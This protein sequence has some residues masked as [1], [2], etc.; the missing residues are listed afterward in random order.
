MPGALPGA[1][2]V[3]VAL[4]T[5][6]LA[7]GAF[8]YTAFVMPGDEFGLPDVPTS[9]PPETE[10]SGDDGVPTAEVETVE[11]EAI[12]VETIEVETAEEFKIS[13][14]LPAEETIEAVIQPADSEIAVDEQTSALEAKRLE[15]EAQAQEAAR[16]QDVL[17]Q[18]LLEEAH[19]D[20]LA[21]RVVGARE[22]YAVV[23]SLEPE[24]ATALS[25]Y[26]RLFVKYLELAVTALGAQRFEPA[27]QHL[28]NAQTL[29]LH[30]ER[31]IAA[32]AEVEAA[33]VEW[34]RVQRERRKTEETTLKLQAEIDRQREEQ[35]AREQAQRD[36]HKS[37]VKVL[38]VE[39]ADHLSALRLTSPSGANAF[40]TYVAVLRM[41][42]DNRVGHHRSSGDCQTL[43]GSGRIGGR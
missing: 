15:L 8:Y 27:R 11:A 10:A 24:N 36:Q 2:G 5:V 25:G 31:V 28:E 14:I 34:E 41:E 6:V 40:E 3:A 1:G 43:S 32:R 35:A 33:R 4:L 42:P 7:G 29:G 23:L 16:Q 38:L 17:V 26:E 18:E 37:K 9:T 12:Q 19:K 21:G 30:P 20:F 22:R 13:E 39:G